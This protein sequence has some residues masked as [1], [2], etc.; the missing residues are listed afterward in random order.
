[1]IHEAQELGG[2]YE[3]LVDTLSMFRAIYFFVLLGSALAKESSP[4]SVCLGYLVPEPARL[5]R[6]YN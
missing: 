2:N 3:A 6:P 1:M 5:R 4:R